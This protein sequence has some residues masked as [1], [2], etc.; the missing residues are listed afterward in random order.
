MSLSTLTA[1][2]GTALGRGF[3]EEIGGGGAEG[4]GGDGGLTVGLYETLWLIK[5]VMS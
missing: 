1:L 3:G 2:V 5:K 4:G